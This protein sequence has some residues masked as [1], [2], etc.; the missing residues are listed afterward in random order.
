MKREIDLR[1]RETCERLAAT[2][3]E[4]DGLRKDALR[5]RAV[6][7]GV[8]F[9]HAYNIIPDIFEAM[10]AQGIPAECP[11]ASPAVSEPHP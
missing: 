7:A 10:A 1:D 5:W 9:L 6:R 2:L 3:T 11:P 8:Q 4:L